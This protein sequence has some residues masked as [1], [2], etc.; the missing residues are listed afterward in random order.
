MSSFFYYFLNE[1]P[2]V[3]KTYNDQLYSCYAKLSNEVCNLCFISYEK[4]IFIFMIAWRI[5][6]NELLYGKGKCGLEHFISKFKD[7]ISNSTMFCICI[8]LTTFIHISKIKKVLHFSLSSFLP[9]VGEEVNNNFPST[10]LG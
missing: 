2:L 10:L 4:Y 5:H 1:K 8:L 9:S 6:I 3:M 7:C